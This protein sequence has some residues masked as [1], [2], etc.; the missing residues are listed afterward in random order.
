M[1]TIELNTY[2]TAVGQVFQLFFI[3]ESWFVCL[4]TSR[5]Q[6]IHSWGCLRPQWPV[7]STPTPSTGTPSTTTAARY[8][9]DP[10]KWRGRYLCLLVCPSAPK[11]NLYL[12]NKLRQYNCPDVNIALSWNFFYIQGKQVGYSVLCFYYQLWLKTQIAF[13]W[14]HFFLL[15]INSQIYKVKFSWYFWYYIT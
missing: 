6:H 12:Q 8:N 10:L 4:V 13:C 14:N 15:Y 7:I 1:P 3:E 2:L 11:V 9:S 5:G